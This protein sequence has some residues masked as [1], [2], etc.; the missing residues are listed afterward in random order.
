MKRLFVDTSAWCAY[1]NRTDPDLGRIRPHLADFDGRLVTSNFIFDET[2]TFCAT[3]LGHPQAVQAG[4][5]LKNPHV[6]DLVRVTPEDEEAAWS[7][8]L[9]RPDKHYSFTNC[10]SFVLLH[11]LGIAQAL[12]LDD[13][14]RREG[15]SVYPQ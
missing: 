6:V 5:V 15:F 4:V 7:L 1:F 2:I 3:R 9:K 10:T 12:S 11:R 8:F 13:D 14:F